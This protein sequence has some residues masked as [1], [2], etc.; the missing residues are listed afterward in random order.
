MRFARFAA[1]KCNGERDRDLYSFGVAHFAAGDRFAGGSFALQG[2]QGINL[3]DEGFL[4]KERT[5]PHT[6][7]CRCGI[8]NRTIRAGPIGVRPECTYLAKGSWCC[9]SRRLFSSFLAFGLDCW[10]RAESYTIGRCSL[11]SAD[12]HIMDASIPQTF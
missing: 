11:P 4:C 7:K 2:R 6:A 9:V 8:F 10:L 3:A 1:N 12:A 5:K